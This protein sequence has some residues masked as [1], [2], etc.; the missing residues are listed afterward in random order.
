MQTLFLV[1]IFTISNEK[2]V[3]I[4]LQKKDILRGNFQDTEGLKVWLTLVSMA[5][6]Y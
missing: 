1:T 6:M 3:K 2:P 5:E 4:Q